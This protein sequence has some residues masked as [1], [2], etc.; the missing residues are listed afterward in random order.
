MVG[1]EM[2]LPPS[3]VRCANCHTREAAI[4]PVGTPSAGA[5]SGREMVGSPLSYDSLLRDHA[6]RGGPPS[7]Y[8]L[9]AFCRVLRDGVDPASVVIPQT[10]PR[11]SISDEECRDLWTYVITR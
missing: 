4:A 9:P 1:H 2:D 5:G 10:M 3:V 11:Y 8:T 7:R 6:R